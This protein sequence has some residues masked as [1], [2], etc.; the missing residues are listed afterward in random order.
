MRTRRN[1]GS[2]HGSFSPNT[3]PEREHFCA[4]FGK[5]RETKTKKIQAGYSLLRHIINFLEYV[6]SFDM[7]VSMGHNK[8]VNWGTVAARSTKLCTMVY[9]RALIIVSAFEHAATRG[10]SWLTIT[11]A[12]DLTWDGLF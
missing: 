1:T 3:G 9:Q 7:Y 5:K 11:Y 12:I 4:A 8:I 2:T 6:R 10:S